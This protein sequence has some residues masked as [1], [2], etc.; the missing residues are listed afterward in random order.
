MKSMRGY[1]EEH[2]RLCEAMLN[3]PAL[4]GHSIHA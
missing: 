2:I 4:I 1:V 3:S